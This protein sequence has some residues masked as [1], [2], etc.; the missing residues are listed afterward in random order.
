MHF[1]PAQDVLPL[2]AKQKMPKKHPSC[3]HTCILPLPKLPPE[4]TALLPLMG[5]GLLKRVHKLN[6]RWVVKEILLQ[7]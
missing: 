1:G 2:E 7:G 5:A 6:L 4:A 3:C